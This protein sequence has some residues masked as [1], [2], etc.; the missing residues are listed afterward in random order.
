MG[1]WGWFGATFKPG[2]APRP[3]ALY[4]YLLPHLDLHLLP[5]LHLHLLPHLH[6]HLL[7][8]LVEQHF[9][10]STLRSEKN[11]GLRAITADDYVNLGGWQTTWSGRL[12]TRPVI[13]WSANNVAMIIWLPIHTPHPLSMTHAIHIMMTIKRNGNQ[14]KSIFE[15]WLLVLLPNVVKAGLFRIGISYPPPSVPNKTPVLTNKIK[16]HSDSC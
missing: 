12:I 3:P 1:K 6:L 11:T 16:P 14:M 13:T 8:H 5:Y 4:W 7:P 15:I 10:N 2:S 9:H